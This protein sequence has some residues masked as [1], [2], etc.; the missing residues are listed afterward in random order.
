M[1]VKRITLENFLPFQGKQ[2][3]DFATDPDRNVTLIM[4][5]NGAGKTSL[6]QAF[7]WC[8]YGSPPKDSPQVINAFVRDHI[9]PGYHRYASV[10]LVIEKDGTN[11]EIT[12]RQKYS[13]RNTGTLERPA[14]HEFTITYRDRG[15]TRQVGASDRQATI[16]ML[17]SSQLSHYFFFDGEHVKSMRTEIERGKSSDFAEAVK[18]ILGLQ[19]IAS[20]LL[21]LKDGP[22][23][24]KTVERWFN[25]Q[26]DYAGNKSLQAKSRR[27][28]EL[29]DNIAAMEQKQETAEG[30]E[31]EA[32]ANAERYR[33]QLRDNE[34]SERAQKAVD[35][36]EEERRRAERSCIQARIDLF[37]LFR[38]KHHRFFVERPILD[39]RELLADEDKIS[40]G[41]PSVDDKTI[42]FI[43]ERG[44]CICGTRFHTGDDVFQHLCDLLAYVPPKDLGTYISEFDKECRLRTEGE[45]TFYQDLVEAFRRFEEAEGRVADADHNLSTARAHL[46]GVKDVD[47]ESIRKK[48]EKA[49][50]DRTRAAGAIQA[51]RHSVANSKSEIKQLQAEIQAYSV[52]NAK[53]IEIRK[54]LKY[55]DYIY[56]FLKSF[57]TE[58]EQA[59]RLKL[60]DRVNKF[61]TEMYDGELHLELDENYG[62]TVVVDNIV[63]NG[64]VWKTSSGQTL[65]IILAFIL[66]I[67][68]I[69]KES[70]RSD[71]ELLKGDTYPL[72]MDAPLSDFDKTRIGTICKLLPTVAEQV[73]IIIK[74]T[75]GDLAEVHMRDRIGRRYTIE[76]IRDY[77]SIVR[78]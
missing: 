49:E 38:T 69:A 9:A 62:V 20:A 64:E 50:R 31:K 65:A 66:G 53:N 17:L 45:S 13:R 15:Q 22:R 42:K 12:R 21:H 46:A 41:V 44:E 28:E 75:D 23:N 32:I 10:S 73:V 60:K 43:L 37:S 67:L 63:T 40:K 29:R 14:P 26:I 39:A 7:E 71:N 6:A 51:A 52:K 16:D 33:Q 5:D 61:F 25:D 48:L 30:D 77:E 76:R 36:A 1:L 34:E 3:I 47:V 24:S 18:I 59:T 54:C 72:V 11:Y 74:D 57:Y 78:E 19:P 8:L 68:D 70:T 27:I 2:S 55:V 56:D 58:H 35:E 4:G